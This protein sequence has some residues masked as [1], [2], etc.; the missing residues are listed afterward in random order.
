MKNRKHIIPVVTFLNSAVTALEAEVFGRRSLGQG[1]L[2]F[3]PE[4]WKYVIV[5]SPESLG[6][7]ENRSLIKVWN[8]IKTRKPKSIQLEIKDAYKKNLDS[9]VFDILALTQGERDAVYEAVIDLVEA[10]LN[11]ANSL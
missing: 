9:I 1:A 2:D 11:K 10:R 5:P 3:P 6:D 8:D 4:D 7:E